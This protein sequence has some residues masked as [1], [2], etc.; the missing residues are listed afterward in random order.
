ML[1]KRKFLALVHLCHRVGYIRMIELKDIKKTY[2]AGETS[3]Q[4]VQ[5]VSLSIAAG[6]FVAIMGA[7]GSGKSTLLHILGFLD[8]PDSGSY[9]ICGQEIATCSDDELAVLRNQLAG[10]VFQQ[11]HLLPRV[12]ARENAELPLIYAGAHNLTPALEKLELVGLAQRAGHRPNQLS[13]G[14]QQRVAISRALVNEPLI[15]FADEPTGNLD[16]KSEQEIMATLKALNAQGK[17][18]IMVTHEQEVAEQASRIIRMRDGVIIADERKVQPAQGFSVESRVE[19][20][21]SKLQQAGNTM[22]IK[23]YLKQAFQSIFSNK[24]R[25]FLSMLGITIGVGA[26]IAMSALGTGAKQSMAQQ[27]SSLGTNVLSIY[28]GSSRVG[29]VAL[30]SGSVTRFTLQ[31]AEA[32]GKLPS[33]VAASP[34]VRGSAQLVYGS[35][36]WASRLQGVTETYPSIRAAQPTSGRFFTAAEV[37]SRKKVAVIGT[38]VAKELFG[39]Q[40]PLGETLKIN[41]NSFTIIGVL[42]EK[43]AAGFQDQDDVVIIPITTA[44]FRM[45]GKEYVDSI[46]IQV[47]ESANMTSVQEELKKVIMIRHRLRTDS[48]FQIR[49]MAD[50]RSVMEGMTNTMS[51]L[52][53]SI[54]AISLLV[55]GIGIMN[56]ML[57]SV[58]ERTKE[59]G[60][61]KA[62]GAKRR[63]IL[64]QFL[65]E[66]IVMTVSGG[67]L[68]L[69][70]GAGTAG[71][72]SLFAGWATVVAPSSVLT[73]VLFS[74]M[75]GLIFGISP[76]RRAAN[77]NPIEAL[78]YE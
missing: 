16:T 78:R 29:G 33:V 5:G 7:S 47:R 58:T 59:I 50:I 45:L 54:A 38:T 19:S 69:V 34:T 77:L 10:F 31:D 36:N 62:I 32:L 27:F 71:A 35:K 1:Q 17:T 65:I 8:K 25:S 74:V 11:F 18:I 70:L 15:I 13:G 3:V 53:G 55:G 40:N 21:F 30:E 60:L 6:E 44:M 48:S 51:M 57:V 67:I 49:N 64:T 26:V 61:R 23:D 14:E 20:I 68:G 43:G 76:A 24:L 42:P 75:V 56:I 52:L 28:P 22:E 63:D 66:A 37:R 2:H 4:A 12:S 41:R 46:D 73:A 9:T 72:L 39:T